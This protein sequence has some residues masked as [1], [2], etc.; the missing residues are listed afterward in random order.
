MKK[1]QALPLLGKGGQ[2]VIE[3]I[4]II[5]VVVFIIKLIMPQVVERL[6]AKCPN[7]QSLVCQQL[8]FLEESFVSQRF[9]YFKVLGER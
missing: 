4:L 1:N 5:L 7:S 3:Y 2:A 9:R 6:S 8:A